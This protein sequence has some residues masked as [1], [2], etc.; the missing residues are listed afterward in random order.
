MNLNKVSLIGNLTKEPVARTTAS[1]QELSRFTLATNYLSKGKNGDK[2]VTEFHSIVAW[3]GLARV[4]NQYLK[5]GSKIYLEGR[6]H[7]SSWEGK[8]KAKH[9]Q[10]EIV[11]S[12]M[13]MLDSRKKELLPEVEEAPID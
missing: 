6:L 13:I 2:K 9:Y 1:C 7:N 8:D 4:T 5:K 11:A 12:E 3:G 10:T